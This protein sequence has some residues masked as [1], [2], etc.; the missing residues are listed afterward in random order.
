MTRRRPRAAGSA[1]PRIEGAEAMRMDS[2][3]SGRRFGT[4][5]RLLLLGLFLVGMGGPV[6]AAADPNSAR[7]PRA[8]IEQ[9]GSQV[10]EI[11]KSPILQ[12][13]R[14]RKF[15]ELFS[16]QFDVPTIGRFVVGRYWNRAS[17]DEQKQY[18]DTFQKYVAA[19]YAQ[20]FSHYQGEGFK[21]VGARPVGDDET[22]VK[23]E[24]DRQ[25]GPP[26]AV[27]FRVKGSAGSFKIVDV[28][29][30]GVSLIITKRDEF[31]SVLAQ[32]GV[33]GVMGRMQAALKDVQNAGT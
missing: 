33:K 11:I 20:Q 5:V 4:A 7:D 9:L 23:A 22:A 12:A 29:V 19:I 15:D 1:T 8:F 26:I 2:Q 17:P 3:L 16:R 18:L 14:Q 30:E 24:I 13:E 21:T 31:S 32:E 27:E 28:A 6:C 10:L 25:G